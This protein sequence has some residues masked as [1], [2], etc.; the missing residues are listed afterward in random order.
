MLM[1]VGL[2]GDRHEGSHPWR[3]FMLS[4]IEYVVRVPLGPPRSSIHGAARACADALFGNSQDRLTNISFF[5]LSL[6]ILIL[7]VLYWYTRQTPT[8][9][10]HI[11]TLLSGLYLVVQASSLVAWNYSSHDLGSAF[12]SLVFDGLACVPAFLMLKLVWPLEWADVGPTPDKGKWK[13]WFSGWKKGMR[14]TRWNHRERRNLRIEAKVSWLR[15]VAVS[16]D[17]GTRGLPAVLYSSR[18]P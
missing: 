1:V 18:P 2:F 4:V 5:A 3:R 10:S 12:A 16:L 6:P 8:G 14:R 17:R 13:R 11:G 9:V 15:V 7:D